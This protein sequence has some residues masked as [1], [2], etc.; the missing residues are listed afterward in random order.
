M[1]YV[2]MLASKMQLYPIQ[3][4]LHANYVMNEFDAELLSSVAARLTP[5]NMLLSLTAPEVDDG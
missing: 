5:D 1:G 3:E 4:V 2:S